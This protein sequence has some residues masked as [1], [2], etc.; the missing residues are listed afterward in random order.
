[1]K[2]IH[3]YT[4]IPT[5]LIICEGLGA[6]TVSG[7]IGGHDYVDLALPSGNKW[8]TCNIGAT[9]TTENGDYFAWGEINIIKPDSSYKWYDEVRERYTKYNNQS[10]HGIVDNKTNLES[11]DDVACMTWGNT[12]HIPTKEEAEEL[13]NN[14]SWQKTNNFSDSGVTGYVGISKNNGNTIFLPAAGCYIV[15]GIEDAG[16][17]A[18]YWCSSLSNSTVFAHIIPILGTDREDVLFRNI[19]LSVRAVS[20]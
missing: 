8:A 19:G 14:C 13:L 10:Y 12:W 20:R 6:Q 17:D 3:I 1:M 4:I 9:S 2:H 5:L 7:N 15:N 18:Y 11:S 16:R